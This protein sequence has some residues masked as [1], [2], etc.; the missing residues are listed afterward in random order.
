VLLTGYGLPLLLGKAVFLPGGVGI[1]ESTMTAIYTSHGIS[2]EIVVVVILGYRLLSF[3]I[4]ALFGFPLV[5]YLQR[6]FH[7]TSG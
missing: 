1:V 3:W 6:T 5:A 7:I 4:P 2:S